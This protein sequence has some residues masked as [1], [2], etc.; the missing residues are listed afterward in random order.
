MMQE[1]YNEWLQRSDDSVFMYLKL[2]ARTLMD[3]DV[4]AE[5]DALPPSHPIVVRFRQL[6][7]LVPLA[8]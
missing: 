2:T 3:A 6:A 4:M 8:P 7:K 1:W 5:V